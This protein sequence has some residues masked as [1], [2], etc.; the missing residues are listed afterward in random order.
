M[1]YSVWH[2]ARP[3]AKTGTRVFTIRSRRPHRT[4][5]RLVWSCWWIVLIPQLV[6]VFGT[7]LSDLRFL[8]VFGALGTLGALMLPRRIPGNWFYWPLIFLAD[9]VSTT[10]LN[11]TLGNWW[12]AGWSYLYL[13]ATG[14]S[15]YYMTVGCVT[16]RR[17]F[18][19][20][21]VLV[22][23]GALTAAASFILE[24]YALSP[25][26][27][28]ELTVNPGLLQNRNW[29][30]AP[31]I[32]GLV[33]VFSLLELHHQR[34][35]RVLL[36]LST[37]GLVLGSIFTGS[38]ATVIS[39][40]S[41]VSLWFIGVKSKRRVSRILTSVFIFT[42]L[43]L[44][45]NL[46]VVSYTFER[47]SLSNYEELVQEKRFDLI[48][49]AI[50]IWRDNVAVGAGFGA[51]VAKTGGAAH[52]AFTGLLAETGVLGFTLFYLP[53][54]SML[55]KCLRMSQARGGALTEQQKILRTGAFG[56]LVFVLYS[57]FNEIYLIKNYYIYVG[58]LSAVAH[59][60]WTGR[61]LTQESIRYEHRQKYSTRSYSKFRDDFF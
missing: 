46:A 38:R 28:G 35:Q 47:L 37:L 49:E 54:F 57:A 1:T 14:V 52:M 19:Q 53:T 59:C 50:G 8:P 4:L 10:A 29:L 40:M 45:Q 16:T 27:A 13:A 7:V 24:N 39:T 31:V 44:L 60:S 26:S 21:S 55:V 9:V 56:L 5:D 6:P 2:V 30:A 33:A 34:W 42:G 51:V 18:I 20:V 15:I 61:P 58:L 41:L 11:M 48:M 17:R 36:I 12:P 22:V 3:L 32:C 23:G 43:W 25:S